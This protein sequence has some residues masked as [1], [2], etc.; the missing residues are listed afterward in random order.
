MNVE[1]K[2]RILE[3]YAVLSGLVMIMLVFAALDPSKV[4]NAERIN[5][6]GTDGKPRLVMCNKERLPD[7]VVNGKVMRRSE[8]HAGMLFYNDEGEEDGGLIFGGE[9]KNGLASAGASLTFDQYEQDQTIQL[10]YAEAGGR[11][12]AHLAFYDRPEVPGDVV[13]ARYDAIKKLTGAEKKAALEKMADEGLLPVERLFIG[14][15]WDKSSAIILS[16][17]K[18]R[19]RI[20]IRVSPDGNPEILFLDAAGKVTKKMNG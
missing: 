8:A 3:I 13:S 11:R 2:L 12:T 5:V 19:P 7:A 17:G 1:K 4:I 16:D 9:K 14:K 10:L 18:E 6:L 20:K 15:D